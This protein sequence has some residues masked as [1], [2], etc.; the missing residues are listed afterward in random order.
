MRILFVAVLL[1]LFPEISHASDYTGFGTII[2][3]IPVA[4]IA[5]LINLAVKVGGGASQFSYN[6]S[7][8]ATTATVLL[9]LF[10][11][12]DAISML[13]KSG[14]LDKEIAISLFVLTGL[15]VFMFTRIHTLKE[16][17]DRSKNHEP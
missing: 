7:G 12:G 15:S 14:G 4:I 6:L 10:I 5:F 16:K 2:I 17:L 3:G 1:T 11:S 13:Q 9:T 8:F